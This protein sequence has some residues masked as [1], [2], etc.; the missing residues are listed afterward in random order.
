MVFEFDELWPLILKA[1]MT[2]VSILMMALLLVYGERRIVAIMQKRSGSWVPWGPLA[3]I[4]KLLFKEDRPS[5]S[6][7][8]TP[9]SYKLAPLLAFSVALLPLA[10]IPLY[11]SQSQNF[12]PFELGI[13]FVLGAF[14]LAPFG[15]LLAG[16]SSRGPYSI[17]GAM[18]T[19]VQVTSCELPMLFA[20]MTLM[21][22]YK[23]GSMQL[24]ME[25]QKGL[26]F[27]FLPRWGL[28]LQPLAAL[29]FLWGMFAKANRSPFDLSRE[30]SHIMDGY[31]TEYNSLGYLL[32]H[33]AEYIHFVVLSLFFTVLFLGGHNALPGLQA[34]EGA[35]PSFSPVLQIFSLTMKTFLVLGFFI[36]VRLS[37]PRYRFDQM[38]NMSWRKIMPLSFVNLFSTVL[39][40]Y[41]RENW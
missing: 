40:I 14:M 26:L 7:I 29:L 16:Y 4:L 34:L 11:Q 30:S 10:G 31:S 5:Y 24:I 3:D 6:S 39:I 12:A 33:G 38:A 15:P 13:F 1:S 37:F 8:S 41:F 9:L 28:F 25:E 27:N 35:F 22:I 20:V 36:W 23:T 17:L 2:M 32:L 19:C 18:R 21:L